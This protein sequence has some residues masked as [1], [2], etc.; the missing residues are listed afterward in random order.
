MSLLQE[1]G[2]FTLKFKEF[3]PVSIK[4]YI[5]LMQVKKKFPQSDI[6]SPNISEGVK[7]GY[8]TKISPNV[9]IKSNV[10]IGDYTYINDNTFIG[11]AVQIGNFCS[12]AY[13]CQ[14]GMNEHPTDFVS[15]SP[16]LYSTNNILD[17]PLYWDDYPNPV[18]I[19]N[20]VWVG[21]NAVI[22]QGVNI[23]DGSIIASGA[24]VTKNVSPYTIVGG[25]PAKKIKKRFGEQEISYL[26]NLKWW[27]MDEDEI[28]KIKNIFL[29]K[30]KWYKND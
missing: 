14:I 21:S 2:E 3:I 24:V 9:S 27:D 6:Y 30:D 26:L 16:H 19:G 22:L 7:L 5:R 11:N 15:T 20:D 18:V 8:K 13:N 4:S 23:G 1:K 10:N 28:K 29:A 12:I 25:I 17:E